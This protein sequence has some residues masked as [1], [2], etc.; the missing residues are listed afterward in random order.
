MIRKR[1]RASY[2]ANWPLFQS[3][4]KLWIPLYRYLTTTSAVEDKS[5]NGNNG[6]VTGAIATNKGWSFDGVDDHI[7]ITSNAGLKFTGN[8]TMLVWA[9]P[10]NPLATLAFESIVSKPSQATWRPNY[11]IVLEDTGHQNARY[12]TNNGAGN[13]LL[14]QSTT[15]P[16]QE[17]QWACFG[18]SYDGAFA[19]FYHNGLNLVETAG[20]VTITTSDDDV[21]VGRS[22]AAGA[23]N[24]Y[25]K[26]LIGDIL[27]FNRTLST[28]DIDTYY[29]FTRSIYGV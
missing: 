2:V 27:I 29:Q 15:N 9:K 8:H 22:Y 16:V 13:Y 24:W 19:R 1:S 3:G 23:F 14:A 25:F 21:E 17:Y 26:G 28:T 20:V 6:T 18:G 7:T 5:G 4:L 11:E 12:Q 10:L